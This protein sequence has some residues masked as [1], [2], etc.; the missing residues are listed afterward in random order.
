M[1]K[2]IALS[3][4]LKGLSLNSNYGKFD[5]LE[6]TNLILSAAQVEALL[7][8]VQIDGVTIINS[9]IN[10][11]II[12]QDG[13]NIGY[14]TNIIA[15]GDIT[16]YGDNN[17][18]Y[19]FW[20]SNT[21][22][23]TLTNNL[24][25]GGCSQLGNL[26][27]CGNTILATNTD[28]NV[29]LV[30]NGTGTIDLSGPV[31]S[32][33][34]YG[35][36]Y[37]NTLDGYVSLN[38]QNFYTNTLYN[39]DLTTANGDITL[40]TSSV[41]NLGIEIITDIYSTV[42]NNVVI[43][44]STQNNLKIGDIINVTQSNSSPLFDGDW[45]ITSILSPESFTV[46]SSTVLTTD[47]TYGNLT[48]Y[49]NTSINLNAELSVNIP[50]DILFKLGENILT[51]NTSGIFIT[52]SS[53]VLQSTGS[54]VFND[55]SLITS[56]TNG[57][58][59]IAANVNFTDPILTLNTTL[60]NTDTG[61]Q[62]YNSE[63]NLGWFGWKQ[64]TNSFSF[65]ES[66]TNTNNIITGQYGNIDAAGLDIHCGELLNVSTLTACG[67][68]GTF[69]ISSSSVILNDNSQIIFNNSGGS[70]GSDTLGNIVITGNGIDLSCGN[71]SNVDIITGCSDI[72]NLSA[73]NVVLPTDSYLLF[74]NTTSS[75]SGNGTNL[76]LNG[77]SVSINSSTVNISGNVNIVGSINAISTTVDANAYI[78]PLGTF[79][80]SQ[81]SDISNY[82]TSGNQVSVTTISP[83]YLTTGDYI[84]LKDT[85]SVPTVNGSYFVASAI[86]PYTFIIT[87]LNVTTPA[88]AGTVTS[89]LTVEQGKDVGIQVNYWSTVGNTSVT[90]GTANF[91]TGF[92]GF[93]RTYEHW[94]FYKDATISNNVVT[95]GELGDVWINNLHLFSTEPSANLT[96]GALIVDGGASVYGNFYLGGILD[97][98]GNVLTNVTAPSLDLDVVNKWYLDDRLSNFTISSDALTG[99]FTQGEVIVGSSSGHLE[100][101][102]NFIFDGSTLF[103]Y[104]TQSSTSFTSGALIVSGGI[105]IAENLYLGGI[106]DAN[107]NVITNVT[108]PSVDLDVVNKWYLDDRLSNFTI[109]SEALTGNFSQG[110]V[111]IGSSAGHLEGYNNFVFDGTVLTLDSTICSTS[112]TDGAFVVAGGVG[113][114]C[115][116]YVANG[117]DANGSLITNVTAPS[118]DLDVVNKWY[119]DQAL[120]NWVIST[121]NLITNYSQGQIIVG[122]STGYLEGYNNFVF[123]GTVLTLDST[124]CS[125]SA[126]DGAFVVAGGVGI[127]CNLYV[128]NGIDANGSKITNVTAP[129]VDLD[130][131]NKWYLDDRLSNFTISSEALTGNFSQGQV[132]IGSSAG[133]LEGYSSFTYDGITVS[134]DSTLCSTS[135]T[136]GALVV[137]GGVGIGCNLYV[138]NGID[139]GLKQIKNVD[140]PTDPFD[141]VNKAYFDEI[142]ISE[143]V[144]ELNNNVITPEDLPIVFSSDIRSFI[145]HAYIHTEQ[146]GECALFTLRGINKLTGWEV[147]STWTGSYTD[148]GFTMRDDAGVG[149]LQYTN[150]NTFGYAS[151]RY[152]INYEIYDIAV[153]PQVNE[154]L[155]ANTF[156][157]TSI[158]SLAFDNSDNNIVRIHMYVTNT[159]LTEF[160][161]IFI[162]CLLKG[163]TWVANTTSFVYPFSNLSFQIYSNGSFGT[164]QY[165]NNSSED[166]QIRTYFTSLNTTVDNITLLANKTT[167]T[168]INST[169]VFPDSRLTFK[170]LMYIEIPS[171]NKYSFYEL[172]S[173]FCES[174]WVLNG[175][176]IGDLM[177][178]QF[179]METDITNQYGTLKYTNNYGVDAN[180]YYFLDSSIIYSILPVKRGGTGRDFLYPNAVLRGNGVDPVLASSDFIYKNQTLILGSASKL[181]IKGTA[182][183]YNC[184]SGSLVTFGGAS[185]KKSLYVKNK[186]ITPSVDDIV[187]ELSFTAAN[188]QITQS[189]ITGLVFSN[190]KSFELMLLSSLITISGE[191][192]ANF[193]I[194]G[195]KANSGWTLTYTYIGDDT[196]VDFYINSSTGQL[197]Y[198]TSNVLNWISTTFKYKAISL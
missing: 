120:I 15:S 113:I 148:I 194:R 156:S 79:Q 82:G 143:S 24:N 106:L 100:G 186:N 165:K 60:G 54:I 45:I 146:D 56:S 62:Y 176:F 195:V 116:L 85:N 19:F 20:D 103:L 48:K 99:N 191:Y 35:N 129:S 98:N 58:L 12:G 96:T 159:S 126:T 74:D 53:L 42:G 41:G 101:F 13:G 196:Y 10:N 93:D 133:H 198:T 47:A 80:I 86:D 67:S 21:G 135:A 149:V 92:F 174:E 150:F 127:G 179:Y 144:I 124:I 68:S 188:N 65:Y 70:F 160:G 59:L 91:K 175:R 162:D 73:G 173:L 46:S 114:G 38:G 78:L 115:N 158:P 104:S 153:V 190:S 44:T 128:A 152:N 3:K 161:L 30:P 121:G 178:I 102:S 138:A 183:S 122:G 169:F 189:N 66:A 141:A 75:I 16:F 142:F 193:K 5:T 168:S 177:D 32:T 39:Q 192:N 23:L 118:V 71:L 84:I 180:V 89:D 167:P 49:P 140:Y 88:S 170:S 18:Q 61:I 94:V 136:D 172:Q 163:T 26:R 28:G 76:E 50:S 111:I 123:D 77:Y 182:E 137:A 154:T 164:I 14:F 34:T 185:I 147:C 130:V 108:A 72:L 17:T 52:A 97:A 151:L 29:I 95:G 117:I 110:Q 25:V 51:G 166:Y 181:C 7:N 107:G 105:G 90:S 63:G 36:F 2:N 81:I 69:N 8:G 37:V 57:D 83:N 22:D 31:N 112:T 184:S 119:L 145:M 197:E 171:L 1:S 33:S 155:L 11:S 55:N 134:I 132:I 131:V 139:A 157:F 40:T 9:E 125:T 109:S 187:S 4:P 6:A 87:G 27:I 43:T 64:D